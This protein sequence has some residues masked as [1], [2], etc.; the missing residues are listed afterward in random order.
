MWI[1]TTFHTSLLNH[2]EFLLKT[3]QNNMCDRQS[4]KFT[5]RQKIL[6]VCHLPATHQDL[7]C[8]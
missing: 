5:D 6:L 1:G 8:Q 4:K 3:Q 7:T 2:A